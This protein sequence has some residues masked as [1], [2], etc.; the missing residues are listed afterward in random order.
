MISYAS[1]MLEL[2]SWGVE[3]A[4]LN[5]TE[6]D[7][8]IAYVYSIT[9]LSSNKRNPKGSNGDEYSHLEVVRRMLMLR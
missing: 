1:G 4:S 9:V 3:R 7:F 6:F 8:R 5:A 2:E